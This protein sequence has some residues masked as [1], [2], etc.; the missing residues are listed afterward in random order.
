MSGREW[1]GPEKVGGVGW[2]GV[3]LSLSCCRF[4]A[5]SL[6]PEPRLL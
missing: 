3:Q 6:S 5:G 4:R 2:V 1:Q